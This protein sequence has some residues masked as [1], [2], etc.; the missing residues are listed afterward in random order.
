MAIY[1]FS[2]TVIKRSEGRSATAAAAYRSAERIR[3][4]KSGEVYDYTRKQSVDHTEILVPDHAP[5]WT[6]DRHQLWNEVERV[7]KRKDAQLCREINMALPRELDLENNQQLI[8]GFVQE[9]FVDQ[10]M[11]ADIALHDMNSDN[12]HA[13]VMLTLRNLDEN[14]FGKKNRDWNQTETLETWREKWSEHTNR[15]LAQQQ[16]DETVD[17]RTLKDQGSQRVPQIHLGAKIIEME[18]RGVRTD[19][20]AQALAIEQHNQQITQSSSTEKGSDHE[21]DRTTQSG[22]NLRSDGERNRSARRSLGDFRRR[23]TASADRS[24][25]TDPNSERAMGTSTKSAGQS[26]GGDLQKTRQR[27]RTSDASEPQ[28]TAFG[29]VRVLAKRFTRLSGRRDRHD[30]DSHHPGVSVSERD[31][32]SGGNPVDRL[33]H[34]LNAANDALHIQKAQ[35]RQKA[36]EAWQAEQREKARQEAARKARIRQDIAEREA[37]RARQ[38][39]QGDDEM[40]M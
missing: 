18:Q 34:R 40:E 39:Q 6:Q 26:M 29:Q 32:R 35:E 1:H 3:D 20:G 30:R 4:E 31:Q 13:H 27:R 5:D 9:Q 38:R 8:R 24:R 14:G 12:P 22:E 33:Q 10:G 36:V 37:R 11:V 2:A 15:A 17:H 23:G 28:S 21:R 16:I 19:R 7:E 25:R